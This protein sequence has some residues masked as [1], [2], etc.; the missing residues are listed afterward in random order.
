MA[1]YQ[2][3]NPLD[4]LFF[5]ADE[6]AR[7]AGLPAGNIHILCELEGQLDLTR[8]ARAVA[9]LHRILPATAARL[10][11]VHATGHPYWR[12]D[13]PPPDPQQVIQIHEVNP[14]TRAQW[15]TLFERLF[16]RRIQA[17]RLPA[18][19]FH[20][21]RGL[22]HGDLLVMR[23]PHALMD[24]RGGG[25]VIEE[26][27]RLY[28]EDAEPDALRTLGDEDRDD[29]ARLLPQEPLAEKFRR[30]REAL[31]TGQLHKARYAHL[32][33]GP[34]PEDVGALRCVFRHL[35]PDDS[36]QIRDNA[37]TFCGI[38]RFGDYLRACGFRALH[39]TMPTPP[40]PD[41]LYTTLNVI[42]NRRRRQANPIC[43]NL[44]T[45]LPLAIS[46]GLA[47]DRKQVADAIRDQM[48]N[49]LKRDTIQQTAGVLK[50]LTRLPT[51]WLAAAIK[52]RLEAGRLPT[53]RLGVAPAPSLPLGLMA[54]FLRPLPTFCG[55]TVCNYYGCRPAVPDTGFAID[56]NVTP[57]HINIS[58]VCYEG[59]VPVATLSQL[60]DRFI[61]ALLE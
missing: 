20:I 5:A 44:T 23:W 34:I 2:Y 10:G 48:G 24:A 56:V 27:N 52:P 12:L 31:H 3:P 29:F 35:G 61:T 39:E 54:P 30:L 50:L 38:A 28:E 8:F 43:R 55:S 1:R 57:D 26:L 22:P 17:R 16:A 13:V 9:G 18:V 59:R 14:P 6:A 45:S 40:P 11:F 33:P 58:G 47:D 36:A 37:L 53:P 41:A 51:A 32:A 7:R 46:A 15:L 42:D 60:L 21:F 4:L 25:T 49:H 19:R